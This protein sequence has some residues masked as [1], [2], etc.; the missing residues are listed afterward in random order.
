MG[1]ITCADM[2]KGKCTGFL[3]CRIHISIR[4]IRNNGKHTGY[5]GCTCNTFVQCDHQRGKLDQFNNHL[6]H[7]VIQGNNLSLLQNTGINLQCT[8][9][10]QNTCCQIDNQ[11]GYRIQQ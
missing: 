5:P 3:F 4:H 6:C 1:V 9:M 8:G 10:N 2:I 7:V 11:E